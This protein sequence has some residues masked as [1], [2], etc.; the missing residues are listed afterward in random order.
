MPQTWRAA[1]RRRPPAQCALDA[2]RP[3]PPRVLRHALRHVI[4]YEG[5]AGPTSAAGA[6]GLFSTS[7]IMSVLT[8]AI[9]VAAASSGARAMLMKRAAVPAAMQGMYEA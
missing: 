4:V 5:A 7:P 1:H 2:Y 6:Q 9:R 3:T 8:G